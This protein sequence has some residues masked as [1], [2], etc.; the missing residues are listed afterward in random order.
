MKIEYGEDCYTGS[1]WRLVIRI[2]RL[3][4]GMCTCGEF[5]KSFG[6][7]SWDCSRYR[8]PEYT[9]ETFDLKHLEDMKHGHTAD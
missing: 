3:K 5:H 9:K 8:L 1:I 4:L 2:I 6:R 7:H